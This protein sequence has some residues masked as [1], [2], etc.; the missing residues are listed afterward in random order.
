MSNANA[1]G[2]QSFPPCSRHSH[3]T[4]SLTKAETSAAMARTTMKRHH[5]MGAMSVEDGSATLLWQQ[6]TRSTNALVFRPESRRSWTLLQSSSTS[7]AT[8]VTHFLMTLP[9]THCSKQPTILTLICLFLLRA[10]RTPMS[11]LRFKDSQLT[12][13]RSITHWE[14][15]LMRPQTSAAVTLLQKVN[16][17]TDTKRLGRRGRRSLQSACA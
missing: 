6:W 11:G 10:T 13:V 15:V 3:L 1:A 8:L 5:K 2:R 9:M 17:L 7:S 14:E 16:T 12:S 4:P